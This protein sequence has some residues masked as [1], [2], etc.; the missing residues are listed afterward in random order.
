ME[1]GYSHELA[2][3]E[4][5]YTDYGVQSRTFVEYQPTVPVSASEALEFHHSGNTSDYV[6]LSQT[7]LHL[8]IKIAKK[9]GTK[10]IK[11][12]N[13]CVV[14]LILQSLWRQIDLI[15]QNQLVSKDINTHYAYKAYIDVLSR[16]RVDAENFILPAQLCYRDTAGTMDGPPFAYEEQ[17]INGGATER[18]EFT[19]SGEDVELIGPLY[20][21]LAQQKRLILN[22]V[23]IHLKLWPNSDAFRLMS[24]GA[25]T[26]K[27]E[28][29]D[30]KLNMCLVKL[31]PDVLLGHAAA[32]K[33]APAV[34]NYERSHMQS[35]QI[36]KNSYQFIQDNLF[37]GVTPM[38][39]IIGITTSKA[40]SGDVSRNPFNFAHHNVKSIAFYLDGQSVPHSKPL[41]FDYKKNNFIEG[42]ISLHDNNDDG[43][44]ITRTEYPN[45][46]AFYRFNIDP[47]YT[48]SLALPNR[49]ALSRIEI[50]FNTPTTEPLTAI[51]YGTIPAQMQIDEARNVMI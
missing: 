4:T 8:K 1:V 16:S 20:I 6:D 40:F 48:K 49:R 29:V 45:G 15:L 32:I 31:F 9:D 35:Y 3:F 23:P 39:V 36:S 13:V 5:P 50:I 44:K 21:D 51:L 17:E 43:L 7:T 42:Y 10:I 27:I 26:Y 19:S 33:N 41:Q 38:S 12:N 46:F 47:R 22:G 34:Y 11:T 28:I 24:F 30:A 37:Q 25:E 18:Y 2:L 14:N